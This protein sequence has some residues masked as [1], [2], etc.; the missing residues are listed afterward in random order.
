[1]RDL[2]GD[3]EGR[4]TARATVSQTLNY[5]TLLE[6]FRRHATSIGSIVVVSPFSDATANVALLKVN[7]LDIEPSANAPRTRQSL[8]S[9]SEHIQ[10][11]CRGLLG[12]TLL[13]V[14][15]E[16]LETLL[17]TQH[18][19]RALALLPSR[20]GG[21]PRDR[22]RYQRA[23]FDAGLIVIGSINFECG[24]ARCFLASDALSF[25]PTPEIA[26]RGEITMTS[27]GRNG[28]F[29]N[30]LFQY[31][32][33]K[34]YALRHGLTAKFP[35]WQG[36]DLF[37]LA[38]PLCGTAALRQL[39][40]H[41][42]TD[43]DLM[44]WEADDPPIDADLWGYFQETPECWRRHRQLL[45]QMFSLPADWQIA[46][47][48]W[49]RT[50]TR[51][52]ERSL[53]ALHVR[54]GDYR[55]HS[56]PYFQFVPEQLYLDWLRKIWPTLSDPLLFIATDEPDSV[57]RHFAEFSPITELA[58]LEQL[59]AYVRDF[60]VLRHADGLAVCNSSYSRMAAIL[61]DEAQKCFL[62]SHETGRFEPYQPWIDAGFWARFAKRLP[63]TREVETAPGKTSVALRAVRPTIHVD[64]SDLLLYLL[65]HSSLSGIQR[66]QCEVLR[67]L[68]NSGDGEVDFVGLE[69]GDGLVLIKAS[70]LL[71]II[72]LFRSG[73]ISRTEIRS[74]ILSIINRSRRCLLKAGDTFITL[75]AFWGVKGFGR[76]LQ[77][78]KNAGVVI[79]LFIHDIIP[80]THPEYF[81]A[82]DTRVF[83]K[84][85]VE[86][87]T[88]ADFVLT[89]SEY[90]EG[91]IATHCRSR[92]LN[93]QI[94][95]V[96]LAHQFTQSN[97][98]A[99]AIS[100]RVR[101]ISQSAFVL[102]VG[103][104]E[105]RKNP[106]YLFNLWKLMARS[107]REVPTLVYAG[108]R[109]WLVRD[110]IEQL[111]NCGYLNGKIIILNSVTDGE[112]D[113]L[114]RRCLLTVFPSFA[115]G[116]GLPVG[117]SLAYGK[118]CICAAAGGT[119]EVGKALA[120]YVDPYNVRSGLKQVLHYLN[121]PEARS[122]RETR[123]AQSFAPRSWR[124]VAGDLLAS[125]TSMVSRVS[126]CE[127]IAA[128][129]LPPNKF[130]PITADARAVSLTGEDGSLSAELACVAGWRVP[131][132][133]GVWAEKP[134]ATL[135]F[136][137]K[138]APGASIHL[139]LRLASLEGS[140]HRLRIKSASGSEV[141]TLLGGERDTLATLSCGVDE[142]GLVTVTVARVAQEKKG[143]T[144]G[145][146]WCL[147]GFM[148]VQPHELKTQRRA[149][150]VNNAAPRLALHADGERIRLL[151]APATSDIRQLS[152]KEEF[153]NTRDAFWSTPP[154]IR[155]R[156]PP[157]LADAEDE[158]MFFT[159]YR[160]SQRPPLGA[161][162]ESLA[163]LRRSNQYLSTSRF[164]E[165]VI[166]D[167]LG[168]VRRGF[169]FL[170]GAPLSHTPW[171]LRD[172]DGIAT[173]RGPLARVPHYDGSF[174]I[175]YNGNLHNYYHWLAEGLLLLD[176]LM[177]SLSPNRDLCIALPK[178][179]DINPLVDHRGSLTSLGFDDINVI[180]IGDDL[181]NV[182]EV[183][184]V[185]CDLVEQ[186]PAQYLKS[187]QRRVASKYATQVKKRSRRLLIE[188]KGP[189]RMI[190]NFE[191]VQALLCEKGFDTISLE[192]MAPSDQILLFQSAEFVVG[193]HGAGLANLLFCEPGT[194]VIEFMPSVEMRPFFW[195]ISDSLD[196]RHAVQ[197]CPVVDGDTFQATLEVDL[198]K[199]AA[200]YKTLDVDPLR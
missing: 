14:D 10:Q 24:E 140:T 41:G 40:F 6:P 56:L 49:R 136:R 29:G 1:M 66:V 118:I 157:I 167:H 119:S 135:Q 152:T 129:T 44:L 107:E 159:R 47:D 184:W 9:L 168:A 53:V 39:T 151:S 174:L 7:S 196:L 38:D 199:L 70:D 8:E 128:I 92:G 83:V 17:A 137:T 154:I 125:A 173:E 178:S 36:T 197:F 63:P 141:I 165:G 37:R 28:G 126:R 163:L 192:G 187:F 43:D 148:Y 101:K 86:A 191:A 132:V 112:L 166:F 97:S 109:G 12:D 3:L 120:D 35:N 147:K 27:L 115:E 190:S 5:A 30:Q 193:T 88:F 162:S 143:R 31:A 90:N 180:E 65:D 75:G 189:T 20:G 198:N 82:R 26:S 68:A 32:Y 176:V 62:P 19:F 200:L 146:Y 133:L 153:V 16:T 55:T 113:L 171:L 144:R 71:E 18:S 81:Q 156:R 23:L 114:Y 85:V 110:F 52:G 50:L 79:G 46:F 105:V 104:I 74:R 164:S 13:V 78:L 161:V 95:I 149:E 45:R 25:M 124:E 150:G 179:M 48:A 93:P 73:A 158:D 170:D 182:A 2:T 67:Y 60:E 72:D 21:R 64:V 134:E 183:V 94:D 122:R 127:N 61:A 172:R 108:R 142:T 188:R 99:A 194:K 160:N 138:S 195:I 175:F 103:T 4:E 139:I 185:G 77:Q 186:M 117:E 57:L 15:D 76:L 87:L 155:E 96:P 106:L 102:C 98:A 145:P 89:S 80:I 42:F 91:T 116:W 121:N 123:I 181:I 22:W 169:G 131:E 51:G 33:V 100:E 69:D 59:P 84:A 54:R 34:L 58:S 11:L 130:M 177:N 111:E